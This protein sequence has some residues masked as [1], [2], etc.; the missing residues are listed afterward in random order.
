MTLS[1]SSSCNEELRS[2]LSFLISPRGTFIGS[3]QNMIKLSVTILSDWL[4]G[5]LAELFI[6]HKIGP[7]LPL[8]HS[9]GMGHKDMDVGDKGVDTIYSSTVED[10]GIVKIG[11]CCNTAMVTS[12]YHHP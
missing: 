11:I 5:P 12:R 10:G 2:L 8:N 6:G 9:V 4:P 7:E 1:E 3:L